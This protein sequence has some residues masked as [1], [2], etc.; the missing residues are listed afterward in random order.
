M[1]PIPSSPMWLHS[2]WSC[3]CRSASI[4]TWALTVPLPQQSMQKHWSLHCLQTMAR[5]GCL[6]TGA[7]GLPLRASRGCPLARALGPPQLLQLLLCLLLLLRLMCGGGK[8]CPCGLSLTIGSHPHRCRS[9]ILV[10]WVEI[11]TRPCLVSPTAPTVTFRGSSGPGCAACGPM[12]STCGS[13]PRPSPVI[14]ERS[15]NQHQVCSQGMRTNPHMQLSCSVY[16]RVQDAP[17]QATLQTDE[18]APRQGASCDGNT[19]TPK[20]ASCA[21]PTRA[22]GQESRSPSSTPRHIRHNP[23]CSKKELTANS[24]LK[25]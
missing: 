20:C 21:F 15:T 19:A 8:P 1:P 7:S 24:T 4:A 18:A 16:L 11:H 10:P 9:V 6:S 13:R 5:R 17:Q 3:D 14:R 23:S 22:G 12:P 25:A 2:A